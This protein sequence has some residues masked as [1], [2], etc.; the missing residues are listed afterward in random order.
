MNNVGLYRDGGLIVMNANGLKLDRLK[1]NIIATVKS[2][3]LS[4]TIDIKLV[5]RDFLDQLLNRKILS[6]K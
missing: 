2:E 5:E 4:I 6:L 1:K 3:R